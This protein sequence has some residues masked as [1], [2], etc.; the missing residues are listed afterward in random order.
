MHAGKDVRLVNGTVMD[1]SA[2]DRVPGSQIVIDA[3][4]NILVDRSQVRVPLHDGGAAHKI[5]MHAG[6]G[7]WLTRGTVLD[8]TGGASDGGQIVI[9][10]KN[11][12]VDGSRL[13]V[14]SLSG[15]FGGPGKVTVRA[16]GSVR[17]LNGTTVTASSP[18]ESSG[19]QVS[20]T[21]GDSVLLRNST[22]QTF[23]RQGHGG[24][25]ALSSETVQLKNGRLVSTSA[26]GTGG[27]ITIKT[28]NFRRDAASA[29]D[30]R[31]SL[32]NGTIT[33]EPL[34]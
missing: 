29:L 22:I 21:A 10:G 34:P 11:V 9:A 16:D 4:R 1:A 14:D 6:N 30:V 5:E 24:T 32:G 15:F 17:L 19:G 27:T 13:T 7:V 33:I 20:V 8:A 28:N 12:V 2:D 31:G 25:I 3:G 26:N 23:A 18:L